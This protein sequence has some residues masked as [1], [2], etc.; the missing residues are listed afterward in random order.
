MRTTSVCRTTSRRLKE[1]ENKVP[2]REK[3]SAKG[4]FLIPSEPNG[5]MPLPSPVFFH[6]SMNGGVM[7][8]TRSF[9]VKSFRFRT[10]AVPH[11][12]YRVQDK[13]KGEEATW[14]IWVHRT[15]HREACSSQFTWTHV[16][17][18][19][20]KPFNCQRSGWRRL[21]DGA[22]PWPTVLWQLSEYGKR[23]ELLLLLLQSPFL[24]TIIDSLDVLFAS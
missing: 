7:D 5:E 13:E 23:C 21:S 9:F 24:D 2:Y 22:C 3:Q 18:S 15:I 11:F 12:F 17:I 14:A 16:S 1:G 4:R 20:M 10:P 8:A 6:P 19:I